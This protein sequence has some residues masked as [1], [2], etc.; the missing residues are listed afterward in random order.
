[1]KARSV[2]GI[3]IAGM[4]SCGVAG[5][6]PPA[7]AQAYSVA[8]DLQAKIDSHP[9]VRKITD[10]G[11]RAD[12]SADSK[13]L[14]F[15]SREFGDVFELDVATG[16]TRPL[17]FHFPHDGVL[18]AY[19]L[20]NGDILLNAPRDH[21]PGME[22]YGRFFQSELWLL[23]GD[24]SGPA[25]PFNEPNME[26][27]AVARSGM[28]IAW[29]KPVGPA[30]AKSTDAQLMANPQGLTGHANQIWMAD[31]VI[32]GGAPTLVNKRMLLDCGAATGALA[33]VLAGE[34]KRCMMLEPQNFVPK[35]DDRLTFSVV[36]TAPQTKGSIEIGAYV[37]DLKTNQVANLAMG[38]GYAEAEGVFPDGKW[39]LIEHSSETQ[40]AKATH[41]IDLWR[42][43]LDGGGKRERVTRYNAIDSQL[44]SNQGVV[45]PD[46]RWLAF[47][48]STSA[49]E[50]KVPGQGVGIFLMDLKAAGF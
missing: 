13:R 39:T 38:A 40:V 1:M 44:K 50:A 23:K 21:T 36:A 5:I 20:P 29:A 27:V 37:L 35:T 46:G 9:H 47:G 19:Y 32:D 14:L 10:W 41:V 33:K 49:I 11:S 3:G 28:K 17:S 48:V 8:A 12:W 6:A 26:G 16:K 45:S 4:L 31:V 7:Q 30:P 24:L 43:A 34:G 2:L 42:V 22:R 15:V 18:R 25:V